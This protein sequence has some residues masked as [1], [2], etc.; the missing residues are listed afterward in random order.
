MQGR[1]G[2]SPSPGTGEVR[3]LERS[4]DR[5]SYFAPSTRFEAQG[6]GG[7]I[8]IYVYIYV[9]YILKCM[10]IYIDTDADTHAHIYIYVTM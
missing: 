9:S 8:Y 5:I 10:Y 1:G 2:V 6:L 7:Y 4:I 3:G